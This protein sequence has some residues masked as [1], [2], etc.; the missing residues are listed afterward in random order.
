MES[1]SLTRDFLDLLPDTNSISARRSRLFFSQ[2]CPPDLA[3]STSS[4][5]SSSTTR[6]R[7]RMLLAARNVGGRPEN[8]TSSPISIEDARSAPDK[9]ARLASPSRIARR[10]EHPPRPSLEA[11]LLQQS[12]RCHQAALS[13]TA[14]SARERI[15]PG[16]PLPFRVL[17]ARDASADRPR[18]AQRGG[19]PVL[20][21]ARSDSQDSRRATLASGESA[22]ATAL[23]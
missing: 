16:R 4:R 18:R 7:P 21:A 2:G 3:A 8:R 12:C 6:S 17:G 20:R 10:A 11:V 23:R 19:S 13:G 15:A 5:S 14:R 22:A 9:A 1:P